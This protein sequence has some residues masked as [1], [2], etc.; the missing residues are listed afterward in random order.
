MASVAA[1][2]LCPGLGSPPADCWSPLVVLVSNEYTR[3]PPTIHFI[4]TYLYLKG[5][6]ILAIQSCTWNTIHAQNSRQ[7]SYSVYKYVNKQKLVH[8]KCNWIIQFPKKR[9]KLLTKFLLWPC[10]QVLLF[11]VHAN[12]HMCKI[13]FQVSWNGLNFYLLVGSLH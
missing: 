9:A 3:S 12:L 5:L 8:D 7:L 6:G 10:G 11:P 1:W 4:V 2:S 13:T